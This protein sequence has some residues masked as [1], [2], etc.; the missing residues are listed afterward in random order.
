[1][2]TESTNQAVGRVI[3]QP[4]GSGARLR[5]DDAGVVSEADGA[6]ADLLG[7]RE[8]DLIGKP[9]VVFVGKPLRRSLFVA[10]RDARVRRVEG[11]LHGALLSRDP[12]RLRAAIS[13][14][15]DG[16][17]IEVTISNVE[18]AIDPDRLFERL[19]RVSERQRALAETLDAVTRPRP[20]ALPELDVGTEPRLDDAAATTSIMHDWRLLPS[21]ELL[22]FVVAAH[23]RSALHAELVRS[24]GEIVR[25][26]ALTGTPSHELFARIERLCGLRGAGPMA[27]AALAYASP[28]GSR[29]SVIAAG[30]ASPLVRRVAGSVERVASYGPALGSGP[31]QASSFDRVLL[32]VGDTLVLCVEPSEAPEPSARSERFARRLASLGPRRIG[33]AA[34]ARQL[35]D[36][37]TPDGAVA[38]LCAI[39]GSVAVEP[40]SPGEQVTIRLVKD[41]LRDAARSREQLSSWLE[42]R[43]VRAETIERAAI[44]IS[45]L[46]TNAVAAASDRAELTVSASRGSVLIEVTDDGST[47]HPE[48]A[49]SP[50]SDGGHGLRVASALCEELHVASSAAGTV[51]RAR[52]GARPMR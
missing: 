40:D 5:L 44:V 37:G 30:G 51:I 33:A 18:R 4:A 12:V 35:L 17:G 42:R 28:D 25:A 1:M 49:I 6:A 32:A 38:V 19:R 20:A 34:M 21:G 50:G 2:G 13:L 8:R 52:V 31:G 36:P 47:W 22:M 23:G 7:C 15:P 3:E 41:E 9:F 14:I 27:S 26:L 45:E 16:D 39:R 46:V 11:R 29:A 10:L 43:A 48:A 24:I